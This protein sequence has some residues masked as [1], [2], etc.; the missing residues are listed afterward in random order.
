MLTS[1]TSPTAGETLIRAEFE[2]AVQRVTRLRTCSP[3]Q[4][5]QLE[6]SLPAGVLD[7]DNVI[8]Q[9]C[10]MSLRWF[11]ITNGHN[12]CCLWWRLVDSQGRQA[13][14]SVWFLFA[15]PASCAAGYAKAAETI[16]AQSVAPHPA[17]GLVNWPR[18]PA[19]LQATR[20]ACQ[21]QVAQLCDQWLSRVQ[22][23]AHRQELLS[24]LRNFGVFY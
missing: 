12:P 19:R 5:L 24:V 14:S 7:D 23:N 17:S 22:Q 10:A 21:P 2:R 1:L 4:I 6:F 15:C 8:W 3:S 18:G 9:G 16:W 11:L 13:Y 20:F